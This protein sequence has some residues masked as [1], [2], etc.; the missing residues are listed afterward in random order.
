V[1]KGEMERMLRH[2]VGRDVVGMI[3]VG[4]KE[5]KTKER[6]LGFESGSSFTIAGSFYWA[7]LESVLIYPR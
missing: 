1:G 4:W 7:F 5:M 3:S 2:R 6:G